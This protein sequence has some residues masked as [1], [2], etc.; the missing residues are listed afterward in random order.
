MTIAPCEVVTQVSLVVLGAIIGAAATGGVQLRV[1]RKQR[2]LQRKVAARAILGDLYVTEQML[3][4]VLRRRRWPDRLDI[5][6]PLD[7]WR[8]FRD[9]EDWPAAGLRGMVA[10]GIASILNTGP[11]VSVRS[12]GHAS[13]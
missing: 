4:L 12:K 2:L 13:K 10:G 7:T 11:V 8:E 9:A 6:A 3:E 1:A 5:G